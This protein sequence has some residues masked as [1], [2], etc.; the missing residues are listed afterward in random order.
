MFMPMQKDIEK[1]EEMA[2][3]SIEKIVN[4]PAVETKSMSAVQTKN[5]L[6]DFNLANKEMEKWSASLETTERETIRALA[7]YRGSATVWKERQM[8]A[9][10]KENAA[11]AEQAKIRRIGVLDASLQAGQSLE[12]IRAIKESVQQRLDEINLVSAKLTERLAE[13]EQSK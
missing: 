4:L 2:K 1:H 11:L 3:A 6:S 9:E 13:I 8:I 7:K 10:L 12:A 5:A